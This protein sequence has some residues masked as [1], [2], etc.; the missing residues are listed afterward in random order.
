[1]EGICKQKLRA[2]SVFFRDSLKMAFKIE[3]ILKRVVPQFVR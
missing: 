1:M 3:D 2:K